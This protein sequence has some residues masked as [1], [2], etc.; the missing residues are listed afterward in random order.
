MAEVVAQVY[1]LSLFEVAQEAGQVKDMLDELT[2]V[3]DLMEQYPGFQNLLGSPV[4]S[5]EE[6]VRLVEEDFNGQVS[7]YLFNFLKL[8]AENGRMP[9]LADI[10]AEYR[11]LYYEMENIQEVTAVTAV[12][13]PESLQEKLAQRLEKS[14]GKKILLRNQVEPS[15]VGGVALKIGN[16]QMDGTVR[17]RLEAIGR[18]IAAAQLPSFEA[19]DSKGDL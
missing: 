1:G 3:T 13:M 7:P 18:Q 2:Q 15:V 5:K 4:L 8:L 17:T 6:R 9:H 12:A 10:T 19:S 11:S 14:M 16:R